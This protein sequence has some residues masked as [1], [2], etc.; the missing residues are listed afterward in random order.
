MVIVKIDGILPYLSILSINLFMS[1]QIIRSFKDQTSN[2]Y[3][4]RVRTRW[5]RLPSRSVSV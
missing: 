4:H 1:S 2:E 3:D 5:T